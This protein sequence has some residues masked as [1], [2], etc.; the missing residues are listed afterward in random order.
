M[1]I[2]VV[3]DLTDWTVV[4]YSSFE[5]IPKRCRSSF[6]WLQLEMGEISSSVGKTIFEIK[7][8]N[9]L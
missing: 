4:E 8:V 1:V 7:R 5:K 9:S 3:H 2:Y 6:K